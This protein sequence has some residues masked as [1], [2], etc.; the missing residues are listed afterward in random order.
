M[1]VYANKIAVMRII[2][3]TAKISNL[4]LG[5]ISP[6]PTVPNDIL[7]IHYFDNNFNL[8]FY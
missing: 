6:Y 3:V 5:V 8:L 4:V 1:I 7:I 2:T